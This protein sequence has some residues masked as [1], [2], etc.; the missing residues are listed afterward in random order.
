MT[1]AP[2]RDATVVQLVQFLIVRDGAIM[3]CHYCHATTRVGAQDVPS[4][5]LGF[6]EEHFGCDPSLRRLGSSGDHPVP[7]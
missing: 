4:Q 3:R 7:T 6:Q 2:V 1:S 5:I